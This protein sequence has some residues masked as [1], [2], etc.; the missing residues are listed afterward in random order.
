MIFSSKSLTVEVSKIGKL[1]LLRR[2]TFAI[3]LFVTLLSIV[4]S[5][6][7][8][9]AYTTTDAAADAVNINSV[10][11]VTDTLVS[12]VMVAFVIFMLIVGVWFLMFLR[13]QQAN[14][15]KQAVERVNIAE[16]C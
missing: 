5:I 13:K 6:L 14:S 8:I 16:N 4:Q 3:I 7:R 10:A 12:I 11:V 2:P 15:I 1:Q 9:V